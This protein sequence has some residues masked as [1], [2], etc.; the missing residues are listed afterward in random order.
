[1]DRLIIFTQSKS[2]GTSTDSSFG[3][4]MIEAGISRVVTGDLRE[5]AKVVIASLEN[6]ENIQKGDNRVCRFSCGFQN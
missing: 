6:S 4:T 3:I 1:M 5:L 2:A